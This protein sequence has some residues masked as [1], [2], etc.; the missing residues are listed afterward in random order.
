MVAYEAVSTTIS[1]LPREHVLRIFPS[2]GI[3]GVP[4]RMVC[5]INQFGKRFRFIFI[6]LDTNFNDVAGVAGAF[7]ARLRTFDIFVRPSDT[8][9]TPNALL[10]A[11]AASS[12]VAAANVGDLKSIVCES[13]REFII[14]RDDGPTVAAAIGALGSRS[15]NARCPW[16]DEPQPVVARFSQEGRSSA[17]FEVVAGGR[18]R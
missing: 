17:H 15:R 6:S 18:A 5:I 2:F 3:S 13:N 11:M 10:E 4:L 14:A 12:P 1:S 9:Q 8:E 7:E 16:L